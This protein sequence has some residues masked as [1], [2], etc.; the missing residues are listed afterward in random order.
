M[1]ALKNDAKKIF[2][3]KGTCSQ[4]LCFLLNRE[5]G[6]PRENAER[7]TDTL[8]GGIMQRGHQ[9]GM[10]WGAVLAAG[11]ESFRRSGGDRDQTVAMAITTSQRL[12]ESFLKRTGTADCREITGCNWKNPFSIATYML[13]GKMFACF[14]LAAKWAPE[15]IEATVDGLSREKTDPPQ[16][17]L[18]CASEVAGK[19]GA[20]D[21][22][23]AMAAGFAGGI[24]LSGNACGALGAA[25]WMNNLAWYKKNPGKTLSFFRNPVTRKTLQEFDDASGGEILCHKICGRYF[26]T[27][28][29]HADFIK[30]NGCGKLITALART[31][32]SAAG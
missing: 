14:D 12:L 10:L 19:M 20:S 25:I 22:E 2:R 11:A 27:I 1:N 6:Q 23:M 4:T 31:R 21:E 9:C 13:T 5:F 30:N 18:S 16:A 32:G 24:G 29:E 26:K 8:A 3:K 15:A 17:P 28:D 7:A